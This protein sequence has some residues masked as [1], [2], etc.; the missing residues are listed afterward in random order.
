MDPE[1]LSR[2]CAAVARAG[3]YIEEAGVQYMATIVDVDQ[4][5]FDEGLMSW[6]IAI[7]G[8]SN[9]A[10]KFLFDIPLPDIPDEELL[11]LR[12]RIK[13]VQA[14]NRLGEGGVK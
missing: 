4:E 5:T 12:S 9:S 1:K 8:Y 11:Q 10:A 6:A 14:L 13:E 3:K 7:K 2:I